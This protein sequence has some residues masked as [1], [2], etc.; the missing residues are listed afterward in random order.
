MLKIPC[1]AP[2]IIIGRKLTRYLDLV[3]A[4]IKNRTSP[5]IATRK[6]VAEKSL[7]LNAANDP[8]ANQK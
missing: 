1:P 5:N 3:S 6:K 7:F 2:T 8:I 4:N